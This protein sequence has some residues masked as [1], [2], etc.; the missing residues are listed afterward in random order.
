MERGNEKYYSHHYHHH[1]HPT[2]QNT[3]E[4]DPKSRTKKPDGDKDNGMKS[5]EK[6]TYYY[7][8]TTTTTTM[9]DETVLSPPRAEVQS[10]SIHFDTLFQEHLNILNGN[11]GLIE[12]TDV[13]GDDEGNDGRKCSAGEGIAGNF[14]GKTQEDY[15]NDD[16][17]MCQA[18]PEI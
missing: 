13:E 14:W 18:V 10:Q 3:D 11:D 12:I 15:H 9:D 7:Y 8:E 16:D 1:H 17:G 6:Q 2:H 5:D 4:D